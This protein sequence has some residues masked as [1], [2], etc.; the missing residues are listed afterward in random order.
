MARLFKIVANLHHHIISPFLVLLVILGLSG[1]DVGIG[2]VDDDGIEGTLNFR[3][4]L[5]TCIAFETKRPFS[6]K[7]PNKKNENGPTKRFVI[8]FFF[9]NTFSILRIARMPLMTRP[10]AQNLPSR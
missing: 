7:R 2:L 1:D 5:K 3:R 6:T 9:E 8:L 4:F 10:I